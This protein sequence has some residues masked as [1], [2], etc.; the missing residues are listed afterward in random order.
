MMPVTKS[1]LMMEEEEE[2]EEGELTITFILCNGTLAYTRFPCIFH[3]S[4][5]LT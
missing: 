5:L 1:D 3:T 2:E 4:E